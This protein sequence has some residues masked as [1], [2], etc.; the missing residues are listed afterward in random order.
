MHPL[1]SQTI[2]MLHFAQRS[3]LNCKFSLQMPNIR[4]QSS[5]GETFDV[6]VDVAKASMTIRTMLDGMYYISFSFYQIQTS[7]CKAAEPSL[8]IL[9][10]RTTDFDS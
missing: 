5:D 9:N 2:E 1:K 4:L 10:S 3:I 6:D 7:Y 8:R